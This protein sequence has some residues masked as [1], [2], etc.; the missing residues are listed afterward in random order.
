MLLF[1]NN[2]YQK[3]VKTK[4]EKLVVYRVGIAQWGLLGAVLV[5]KSDSSWKEGP[6]ILLIWG[7]KHAGGVLI[8]LIPI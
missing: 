3:I 7:F 1:S 5:V 8:W 2:E 4:N 6:V